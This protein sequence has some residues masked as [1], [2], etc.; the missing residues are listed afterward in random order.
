MRIIRVRL[1]KSVTKRLNE[2]RTTYRI[3]DLGFLEDMFA[4]IRLGGKGIPD[5]TTVVKL[6]EA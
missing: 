6:A 2:F 4:L 5:T 1:D 3:S